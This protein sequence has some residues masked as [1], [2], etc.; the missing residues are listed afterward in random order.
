V[1]THFH[2]IF[3]AVQVS[4]FSIGIFM[5][6]LCVCV[7]FFICRKWAATATLRGEFEALFKRE[8]GK[9]NEANPR[10]SIKRSIFSFPP[11][12]FVLEV[13]IKKQ[14]RENRKVYKDFK[15]EGF[16]FFR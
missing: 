8:E 3:C 15:F 10:E 4:L 11:T 1:I 5:S 16:A 12:H 9:S 2:S 14:Q 6:I 13:L 7:S